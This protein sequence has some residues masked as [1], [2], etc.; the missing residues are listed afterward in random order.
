MINSIALWL[1]Q[2]LLKLLAARLFRNQLQLIFDRWDERIR[3]MVW[4]SSDDISTSMEVAVLTTTGEL[5][6]PLQRAVLRLLYD[7][8]KAAAKQ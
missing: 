6:A 4:P 5:A 8:L 1:A 3:E 2:E 7:P